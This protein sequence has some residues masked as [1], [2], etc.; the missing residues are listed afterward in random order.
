MSPFGWNARSGSYEYA[1]A[2]RSAG[3]IPASDRHQAIDCSGSSQVE[4][5]TGG[6]PCLRREKRSSSAAAI[7]TPSI[8]TAAAGSWKTALSPRTFIPEAPLREALLPKQHLCQMLN[9]PACGPSEERDLAAV[10]GHGSQAVQRPP[11]QPRDVHLRDAHAL[12]DLGL[13]QILDEAQVEHPPVAR[14]QRRE[15]RRD[16]RPVLDQLE[17]AVLDA[18]RLGVGLAVALVAEAV[19]LERDGVV[20]RR[21]LHRLEHLLVAQAEHL[22]HLSRR[23]RPALAARQVLDGA[24]DLHHALLHPARD[25]DGPAVVTEIP[26]E[27]AEHRRY[28]V[29]G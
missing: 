10:L 12:G 21:G 20:R 9:S 28:R 24:V 14:R 15:R 7:V 22:R 6:L 5:A 23:R 25:V 1:T 16:R 18:D 27:L 4:N 19:G 26:L 2:S 13:C 8:T 11:D 17:A 3:S 29:G